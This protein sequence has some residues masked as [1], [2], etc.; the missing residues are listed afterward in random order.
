MPGNWDPAVYRERAAQWRAAA[1]ALPPGQTRDAYLVI[2]EGYAH[3][4][5][6]IEIEAAAPIP[7][8]PEP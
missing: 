6:L 7:D 2:A 8:D 4:A 3:L 5:K 1:E